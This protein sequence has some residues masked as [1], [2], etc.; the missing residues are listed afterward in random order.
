MIKKR[1]FI[2]LVV[3]AIGLVAGGVAMVVHTQR[4]SVKRQ[5]NE[6][7]RKCAIRLVRELRRNGDDFADNKLERMRT[8]IDT[9]DNP[10]FDD[11][12]VIFEVDV[13]WWPDEG[14]WFVILEYVDELA[15]VAQINYVHE[16]QEA[17]G[18]GRVFVS[19]EELVPPSLRDV[20][21]SSWYVR[22]KGSYQ[23]EDEATPYSVRD[24]LYFLVVP[25][26]VFESIKAK[27][28]QFVLLGQSG[29][30]LDRAPLEG[31]EGGEVTGE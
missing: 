11:R 14:G 8:A 17:N 30:V 2:G 28:G 27:K 19:P 10:L 16:D 5:L 25:Q 4:A 13:K 15:R 20:G 24:E 1:T 31:L 22:M 9:L 26:S 29:D 18:L 12:I 21:I 7:F 23:L 6:L 3:C